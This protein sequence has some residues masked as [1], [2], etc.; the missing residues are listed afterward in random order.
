MRTI[1]AFLAVL[2]FF[3]FS[4]PMLSICWLIGLVNMKARDFLTYN[5]MRIA[6]AIILFICGVK[7]TVKGKEKIPKNEPVLYVGNH[8]S[9]F[10]IICT[11]KEFVGYT[12][13]ISKLEWKKIPVLS[14]WISIFHGFFLDR[15][16]V[17]EGLKV[18]LG[19]IDLVKGG[20][21][22]VCIFPEGT[23]SHTDEMLPFKEGSMKIA[24]KSGCPIIPMAL[25]N[26]DDVFEKH[27]PWIKPTKVTLVFGDPIYIDKLE[28][29]ELKFLGAKT[30]D[31]IQGMIDEEKK[32]S[33]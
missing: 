10:D 6:F 16:N 9:A 31:I 21:Y 18:I 8:R 11:Y 17:K 2:F 5:C 4:I 19:A 24:V 1:I 14:H 15:D 13:F 25:L 26:T 20:T 30:R 7:L 29:E 3:I 12:A 22:S 23:R 33:K 27:M 32:I 28:K